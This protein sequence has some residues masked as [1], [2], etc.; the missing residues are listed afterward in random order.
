[1]NTYLLV[2]QLLM[3]YPELRNSDKKLLWRVWEWQGIAK[4]VISKESFLFRAETPESITRARRKVQEEF[5]ELQATQ[6]IKEARSV[7]EQT[8]GTW[9]YE[10][11][12]A[13]FVQQ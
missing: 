9:I 10:G 6:G 5:P 7:K 2:K 12:V 13:K 8:K 1:M 11:N 4:N 3:K